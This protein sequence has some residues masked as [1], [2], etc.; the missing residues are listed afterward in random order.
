MISFSRGETVIFAPYPANENT[1]RK[2]CIRVFDFEKTK[3][4]ATVGKLLD[5][6]H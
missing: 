1:L 5:E 3:L 2:S 4:D 6:I